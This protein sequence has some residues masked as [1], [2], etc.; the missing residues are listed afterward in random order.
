MLT[1]KQ[2]QLIEKIG[3]FST[4]NGMQP[5]AARIGALLL[6]SNKV[7]L[8]FDEIRTTLNLSKSATSN[9]INLLLTARRIE[10]VTKNGDRK[11]Y[12][13]SKIE[14]W[15]DSF[16]EN[17]NFLIQFS[18]ILKEVREVRNDESPE[19]NAALSELVSFMQFTVAEMTHIYERW[20][21]QS[22]ETNK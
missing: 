6:V 9:G 1:E 16:L 15:K 8:T 20:Q 12:F 18:S 5:S 17:F 2:M 14:T 10:Y 13:R 22:K 19:F 11:R 7:E 21:Q 4:E 3:V